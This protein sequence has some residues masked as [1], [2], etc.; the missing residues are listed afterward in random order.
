VRSLA[1]VA[2]AGL[3]LAACEDTG[4]MA[5]RPADAAGAPAAAAGSAAPGARIVLAGSPFGR[6]VWGPGRRAVYAFERDGRNRSR[7]YGECARLWPPVL[8]RGR[9]VAGPGL[10]RSLIGTTRRRDG[11]RQV[12]YAGRPLYFYAHE[13]PGQ[14]LCHNVDLNGGFWWVV[15]ARGRR[16]P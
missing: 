8:T 7:C 5:G 14:V 10:R 4:V 9:P 12:T 3:A 11:R 1:A 2:V 16:R 15:D 6:I 13:G